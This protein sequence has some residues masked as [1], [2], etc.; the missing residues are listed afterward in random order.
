MADFDV[1]YLYDNM[2]VEPFILFVG[3]K[4]NYNSM[5]GK[6]LMSLPWS[7]VI[8][9]IR[10]DIFS[11]FFN[12]DNRLSRDIF[13]EKQL[14]QRIF[15][16]RNL[17]VIRLFNTESQDVCNQKNNSIRSEKNR[18]LHMLHKI[19]GFLDYSGKILITGC[20][21]SDFLNRDTLLDICEDFRKG[22]LLFFNF[23]ILKDD[24][25]QQM[26]EEK[27]IFT[28]E[29]NLEDLLENNEID[30][31]ED[32]YVVEDY[33]YECLY[34][35]GKLNR[36]ERKELFDIKRV[37]TPLSLEVIN[38]VSVPNYLLPNY[39]YKFLRDSPFQPQWYAYKE[40]FNLKRGYEK[41]IYDTTIR[42]LKYP[43][44]E[45][46]MPI[47][48]TG[49][50][51][52]GKSI[53]LANLAYTIWKEKNYPIIY[54]QN[55]DSSFVFPDNM[56]HSGP[57]NG[58]KTISEYL[59]IL[60]KL[61]AKT[62]LIVLD[63]SAASMIER[64]RCIRLYEMLHK[65]RGYNLQVV[66][67]SYE[68]D[69]EEINKIKKK[70]NIIETTPMIPIEGQESEAL[71]KILREKAKFS[72]DEVKTILSLVYKD[73][74]FYGNFM[75]LLYRIFFEVRPSM[76]QGVRR[77]ATKTI[78]AVIDNIHAENKQQ[79]R[80]ATAMAEAFSHAFANSK[81]K[82]DFLQYG[83]DNNAPMTLKED[84]QRLL[85]SVAVCSEHNLPMPCDMAYRLLPTTDYAIIR[86][87]S[88]V[89]FFVFHEKNYDGDF[90]FWM[91][92]KLEATMLLRAYAVSPADVI[93]IIVNMIDDLK[94]VESY[95]HDTEVDMMAKL[96]HKIGPNADE[97]ANR[98]KYKDFYPKISK[99]LSTLREN[100]G[101]NPRLTLQEIV[102]IREY[103][104]HAYSDDEAMKES[105][106][107]EAVR[108][109]EAEIMKIPS[110][111]RSNIR[112]MLAIE[113]NNSR[114]QLSQGGHPQDLPLCQQIQRECMQVIQHNPESSHAYSTMMYA[115]LNEYNIL[116][117]PDEQ[118]KLLAKYSEIIERLRGEHPELAE[119]TN[120]YDI[121]EQLY[122]KIN[123]VDLS[124][125]Y[126]KK[127]LDKS[128]DA[129]IYLR[130]R[131]LLKKAGI[132]L[133]KGQNYEITEEQVQVCQDVCDKYL[134]NSQYAYI[135][136]NSDQCQ[137]M[138]LRVKW[139]MY[140]REPIFGLEK[141]FTKIP[142]EGWHELLEIC[143]NYMTNIYNEERDYYSANTMLY[144][145]ALSY[146]QMGDYKSANQK[147]AIVRKKT[148]NLFFENRIR[149]NHILCDENGKPLEFGG[150]FVQQTISDE[151]TGYIQL[152]KIPPA[153][154]VGHHPG[155]F[156]H[157]ANMQN[158]IRQ[159]GQ[160]YEDFQIGVGFMGFSVF[161]GL[162]NER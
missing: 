1:A 67:S 120:L 50:T 40:G 73:S 135:V 80:F 137:Q 109:G 77:E 112:D 86:E 146:A 61:G 76:E 10:D 14:N 35:N 131:N 143:E 28:S 34:I 4:F 152:D 153:I 17:S 7:C 27:D 138:L 106:L 71:K 123:A 63:V 95:G 36:V 5:A 141:G 30:E 116:K 148:D 115:A 33:H 147:I 113:V 19:A 149:I 92:T 97:K 154:N 72:E 8:T 134:D 99:A 15:D 23:S 55:K 54:I 59:E 142:L 130:A 104:V 103:S 90:E 114:L 24:E 46:N 43:G 159:A 160:R 70:C 49:Q 47:C 39:F 124:E 107:R 2:N 136:K 126:F 25:F 157:H 56:V 74:A 117:N 108:I 119:Q 26:T 87:I 151:S 102:Y 128:S 22:S 111:D 44:S 66:F 118:T 82:Y 65:N 37:A 93:D 58:F 51:G 79:K 158:T 98:I 162:K 69:Q 83:I 68:I 133:Y 105:C 62:T 144:I 60:K 85:V 161:R 16:R 75:G 32:D 89:P 45:C 81:H 21:E 127:L 38:E 88:K 94:C 139:M 6:H 91:R 29:S 41:I 13:D 140:N 18:V 53:A 96:L 12:R 31:Y 64:N 52:A 100:Y 11:S 125:Q 129:G 42:S 132:N 84:I 121:S 3:N 145:M 155:I 20:E 150:K 78:E 156:Y 48:V 9:T 122:A 101:G 57:L 110:S